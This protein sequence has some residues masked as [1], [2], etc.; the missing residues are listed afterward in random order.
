MASFYWSKAE[1]TNL[2]NS[3]YSYKFYLLLQRTIIECI[4]HFNITYRDRNIF[5]PEVTPLNSS[6]SSHIVNS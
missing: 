4:V 6:I 1:L 3:F 5:L 2:D